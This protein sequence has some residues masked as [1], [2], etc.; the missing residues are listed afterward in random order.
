MNRKIYG[1]VGDKQ[2]L[3]GFTD[4]DLQGISPMVWKLM[5]EYFGVKTMLDVGCGKGLSTSWFATHGVEVLCVEGSHDAVTKTLLP[6]PAV[7]V[8]EHDFS[9][10]AW[11][12]ENTVDAVWCVEFTEHVGRNYQP[13]YVT[14][15]K[16]AALVFVSHS[17]W[18]GWHHVEVHDNVW[19]RAKWEAQGFVYSEE[20]TKKVRETAQKEKKLEISAFKGEK[21]NAQHVWTAMQVFINPSVASLPRHAHL[22]SEDGCHAGNE[23][24]EVLHV[25][26]GMKPDGTRN[27]KV[28]EMPEEWRSVQLTEEMD[29]D[30]EEI[31]EASLT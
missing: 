11:W 31:V 9:R 4:L 16:E 7:Q 2:H 1:G 10:G 27:E 17:H 26:C 12:P 30:W 5:V 8:V 6:N 24:G 20:L 28:S 3:G 15:F 22:F 29:R 13:N 19:W 18:G 23:N 25:K 14:A 21:Y